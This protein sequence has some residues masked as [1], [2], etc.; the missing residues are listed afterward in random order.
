MS[1]GIIR[2]MDAFGRIAIPKEIR[3]VIHAKEN[4]PFEII[5][6]GKAIV[7]EKYESPE[8]LGMVA[9]PVLQVLCK[10]YS[11]KVAVCDANKVLQCF[12]IPM[13]ISQSVSGDIRFHVESGIEYVAKPGNSGL[14]LYESNEVYRVRAFMPLKYGK[15]QMSGVVL[16]GETSEEISSEMLAQM[17]FVAKLLEHQAKDWL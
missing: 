4:D 13:L 5:L 16:L 12:G 2:R 15:D 3:R 11:V 1:D 6:C 7:L 14:P 17:R 9:T 10:E 8:I